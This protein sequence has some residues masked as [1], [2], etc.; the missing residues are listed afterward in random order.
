MQHGIEN[1]LRTWQHST[2]LERLEGLQWYRTAQQDCIPLHSN[3][4]IAC[5]VVAAISPGL[6]W[7]VNIEAARRII[8]GQSVAGLGRIWGKNYAKAIAIIG[9]TSPDTVLGQ[10][11]Q[12]GMKVRAFYACL[13]NP[14]NWVSVVI[15]VHAYSVWTGER[16]TLETM[17]SLTKRQ[18]DNVASDYRRVADRLNVLPHQVQATTWLAWRRLIGLK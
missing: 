13:I 12:S 3:L 11:K 6:K 14:E 4:E 17:V 9:G 8:A 15:D 1:I 18:Y 2:D 16:Y 10:K 7:A 5:G